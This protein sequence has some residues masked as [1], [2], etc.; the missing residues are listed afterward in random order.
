VE[1]AEKM[2]EWS[3]KGKNLERKKIAFSGLSESIE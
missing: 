2:L 3:K 1:R